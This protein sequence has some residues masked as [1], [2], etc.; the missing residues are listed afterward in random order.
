M[1]DEGVR[2]KSIWEWILLGFFYPY[3]L[4]GIQ[5]MVG[6]NGGVSIYSST[7][8]PMNAPAL[9]RKV[10]D[11]NPIKFDCFSQYWVSNFTIYIEGSEFYY[12]H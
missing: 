10:Y 5:F 7:A 1:G 6:N 3:T 4:L 2:L 11:Q 12:Y 9:R 8:V